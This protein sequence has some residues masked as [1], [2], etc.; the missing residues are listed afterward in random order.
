[1]PATKKLHLL[2]LI[3]LICFFNNRFLDYEHVSLHVSDVGLQRGFGIFDYFLAVEGFI[4]FFDDY[5]DR[6]Y[7]SAMSLNLDVPLSRGEMKEKIFSLIHQNG[8]TRS[9][10]KLLLTGGYSDDLYL[11]S[12]PNFFI[13]NLPVTHSPDEYTEG[14]K[15]LLLDYV[16]FK[17]EIKTTFYLPTLSL[18]HELKQ[19][20]ATEVLYHHSGY[21][22]ETTRANMFIIRNETLITPS[23]GVLKGITRKHILQVASGL[24]AA[25]QRPVKLQEV[26]EADEVFITG[27]SKHLAPVV[28]IEDHVIGTGK[29]GR[30]TLMLAEEFNGY[31]KRQ[32]S[33]E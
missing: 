28:R 33:A 7:G 32:Y 12:V 18:L 15:L 11:P 24:M 27:T 1:M 31:Y 26:F 30:F 3:K 8:L 13:I 17:P 2:I 10:V 19:K 23:T 5:L 14:I 9:A 25:E 21:I 6:F 20:S 29:P 22:S 16:R 4:P